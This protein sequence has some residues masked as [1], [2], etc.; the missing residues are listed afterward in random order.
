MLWRVLARTAT[1]QRGMGGLNKS[2][3]KTSSSALCF[4]ELRRVTVSSALCLGK[5]LSREVTEGE[6]EGK[7]ES[8][9]LNKLF[10]GEEAVVTSIWDGGVFSWSD[11]D[12]SE[13]SPAGRGWASS[14]GSSFLVTLLTI[15]LRA[16]SMAR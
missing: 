3:Q 11:R 10:Q 13:E 1:F 9:S 7:A 15:S 6:D 2:V 14:S 8:F 16:C 12:P 4:P 5:S